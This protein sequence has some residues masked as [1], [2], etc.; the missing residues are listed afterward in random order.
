MVGTSGVI[1]SVMGV[2]KGSELFGVDGLENLLDEG[3]F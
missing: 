2:M 3:F 1:F